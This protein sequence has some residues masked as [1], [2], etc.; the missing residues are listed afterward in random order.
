M[1]TEETTPERGANCP[2]KPEKLLG[3]PIG[4]YHCPSCGMMIVAGIP[5][6]EPTVDNPDYVLLEALNW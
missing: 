4:Q 5:H 1:N 2:E 3:Q 6:P